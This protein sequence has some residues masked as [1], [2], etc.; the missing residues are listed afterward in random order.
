MQVSQDSLADLETGDVVQDGEHEDEVK[1]LL[2]ERIG[3]TRLGNVGKRKAG[4]DLLK[5]GRSGPGNLKQFGSGVDARI[6]QCVP[7][8]I[9]PLRQAS[10]PASYVQHLYAIAKIGHNGRHVCPLA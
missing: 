1:L 10:V 7:F 8:S 3:P 2:P 5:A 4:L 6:I 9:Q